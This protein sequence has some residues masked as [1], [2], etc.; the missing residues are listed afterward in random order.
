M[1]KPHKVL[2]TGGHEVGGLRSFAATLS[3]GFRQ[4]GI[5]AEIIS[6]AQVWSRWRELR[7][8]RILKILSTTAVFAAPFS[9]RALCVSHGCPCADVQ[10]WAKVIGFLL[11]YKIANLSPDTP[12]ICVSEY[13]AIHLVQIFNIRFD[14]VIRNPVQS[15]FLEPFTPI[16]GE[17]RYITYVGRLHPSKNVNSLLS[18]IRTMLDERPDLRACII[19]DGI[20]REPLEGLYGGDDRI[21]FTGNLSSDQVCERLRLTKLFLSGNQTEPF[22]ITFLEALSQGCIVAMPASGGGVEIAPDLI[23]KQI[24]LLPISLEH[25]GVARVL[26]RALDATCSALDLVPYTATA[27]ASAYL[28]ADACRFNPATRWIPRRV[29]S[30]G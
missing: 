1:E 16:D 13:S 12:L 14:T 26:R 25:D 15:L 2:I 18:V 22:G 3:E 28:K 21:E 29:E 6:P 11:S 7:D 19:G 24:H 27:A 30:H 10:G 9:R 17:R 4:L 20:S 23:G 5:A 8:P